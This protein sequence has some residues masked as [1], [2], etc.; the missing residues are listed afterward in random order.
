[1]GGAAVENLDLK[2]Q[3]DESTPLVIG[4]ALAPGDPHEAMVGHSPTPAPRCIACGTE[5]NL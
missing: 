5:H 2:A 3:L 1:V 4:V